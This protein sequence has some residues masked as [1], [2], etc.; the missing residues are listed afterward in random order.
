MLVGPE[1]R[2]RFD[3]SFD[4][5]RAS[6]SLLLRLGIRTARAWS[7]VSERQI[8][9]DPQFIDLYNELTLFPSFPMFCHRVINMAIYYA[10]FDLV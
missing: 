7:E 6:L 8:K 10:I 2:T 1:P 9:N 4:P 5:A 3:G